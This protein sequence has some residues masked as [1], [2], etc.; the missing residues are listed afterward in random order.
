MFN[1]KISNEIGRKEGGMILPVVQ[2]EGGGGGKFQGCKQRGKGG[3]NQ[4][5]MQ[6]GILKGE[7]VTV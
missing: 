6:G 5:C 2:A 7:E 4:G 3:N 1:W